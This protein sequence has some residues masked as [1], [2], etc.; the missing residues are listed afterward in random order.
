MSFLVEF[1]LFKRK[2]R[3]TLQT[4]QLKRDPEEI[5]MPSSPEKHSKL[6][7]VT[8][9]ESNLKVNQDST[10]TLQQSHLI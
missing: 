2:Q 10:H 8:R 6:E 9:T 7:S 3:I 1:I 4:P 5:T